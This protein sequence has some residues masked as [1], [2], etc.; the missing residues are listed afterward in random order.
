MK[1]SAMSSRALQSPY[2]ST[3]TKSN[4]RVLTSTI[5]FPELATRLATAWINTDVH[6][7]R[8]LRAH[9]IF[10][11]LYHGRVVDEWCI[12]FPGGAATPQVHHAAIPPGGKA[13]GIPV[14]VLELEDR[15]L[16]KY[17]TGGLTGLKGVTTGRIRVAGDTDLALRLEEMF[18]KLGGVKQA[19][20]YL[21]QSRL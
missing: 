9:F 13:S 10:S 7:P 19:L 18:V 20:E 15:E 17:I 14:V 1:T 11:I 6:L 2:A 21:R 3:S 4:P 5:L 12:L 16:V 8:G